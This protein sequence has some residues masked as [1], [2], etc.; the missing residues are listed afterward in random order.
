MGA[1]SSTELRK[2]YTDH[3]EYMEKYET[4]AECLK[5]I[6][7]GD[8]RR[9]TDLAYLLLS[10]LGGAQIDPERA[11][12]LLEER[13]KKEDSRAMWML[14]LCKEYEIGTK[15]DF[16]GAKALYEQSGE[17]Y[18]EEGKFLAANLLQNERGSKNIRIKGL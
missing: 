8:D 2:I 17:G 14:G 4:Y 5:R 7:N 16:D 11:V 3:K 9:K 6:E 1:S 13:V 10:G 12:S 15:Q 18:G